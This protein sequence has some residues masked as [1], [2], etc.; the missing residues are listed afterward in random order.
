MYAARERDGKVQ[1][2]VNPNPDCGGAKA[3]EA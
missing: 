1:L 3:L 2:N